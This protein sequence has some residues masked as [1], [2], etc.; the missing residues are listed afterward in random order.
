MCYRSDAAVRKR[1]TSRRQQQLSSTKADITMPT[2]PKNKLKKGCVVSIAMRY[3]GKGFDHNPVTTTKSGGG[4]HIRFQSSSTSSSDSEVPVV[5]P[6]PVQSQSKQAVPNK[7]H[8]VT[9]KS[10]SA[11]VG[12]VNDILE[13]SSE[14]FV[15]GKSTNNGHSKT[16][17]GKRRGRGRRSSTNREVNNGSKAAAD[18]S[19]IAPAAVADQ[20]PVNETAADPPHDERDYSL[21]PDLHGPPRQGDKIAFKVT[22]QLGHCPSCF[23]FL[24]LRRWNYQNHTLLFILTTRYTCHYSSS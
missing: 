15:G 4:V 23:Q 10:R 7:S 13:V 8:K 1:S 14:I 2:P 17:F 24:F 3:C 9:S 11:I 12:G 20:P 22:D 19:S 6:K 18:D 21:C 5:K 16:G